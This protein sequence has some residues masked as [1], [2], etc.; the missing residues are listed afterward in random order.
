MGD[1]DMDHLVEVKGTVKQFQWTNPHSWMIVLV[2][3]DKGVVKE[4]AYEGP[5]PAQMRR[6]GIERT[7]IKEGDKVDLK[8]ALKKDGALEGLMASIVMVNGQP[9]PGDF[10][11]LKEGKSAA[12]GAGSRP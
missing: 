8:V 3:D 1:F 10:P 2:A 4:W 9:G 5:P 7:M 11:L 12:E 6:L